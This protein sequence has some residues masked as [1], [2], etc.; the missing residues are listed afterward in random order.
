MMMMMMTMTTTTI[1]DEEV[2][3]DIGMNSEL[4]MVYYS[5]KAMIMSY[6]KVVLWLEA[7]V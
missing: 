3:E 2:E 6:L 1:D 4:R 5:N 7:P